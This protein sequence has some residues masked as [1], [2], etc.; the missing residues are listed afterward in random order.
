MGQQ[1]CRQVREL[2]ARLGISL[3][4]LCLLLCLLLQLGGCP[5]GSTAITIAQ[6]HVARFGVWWHTLSRCRVLATVDE[7]VMVHT[8][9]HGS[10]LVM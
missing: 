5:P 9:K 6:Y 4:L 2:S 1:R 7:M 8:P 10:S 3:L